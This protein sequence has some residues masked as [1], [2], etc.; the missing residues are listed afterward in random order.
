MI[1]LCNIYK[2]DV[3]LVP[4]FISH[5][6]YH[7]IRRFAFAVYDGES[8]SIWK[9]LE[10]RY[11]SIHS[12]I[13]IIRH[14]FKYEGGFDVEADTALINELRVKYC[15]PEEY[16]VPT[17]LDEFHVFP[18]V[19]D[20]NDVQKLCEKEGADYV[21]GILKDR[22]TVDGSFPMNIDPYRSIW[23]QFP[24]TC[25][26]THTVQKS[27]CNKVMMAKGNLEI[28]SGHHVCFSKRFSKYGAT[29]HF[30][31]F[32]PI[33]E[34]EKQKLIQYRDVKKYHWASEWENLVKHLDANGGKFTN[35]ES[36]LLGN[37]PSL[38]I[39]QYMGVHTDS[40]HGKV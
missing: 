21:M 26:V 29:F 16:C 2:P 39:D 10:D 35:D 6:I 14:P 8:N 17:D 13:E 28:I 18:K 25:Y 36:V 1:V 7:G 32:G 4:H 33:Y 3:D 22:I 37:R 40:G 24:K 5:Y 9:Y 31:W 30:K 27:G 15:R 19:R 23:E 12:G 11:M 34:K 20:F 38:E